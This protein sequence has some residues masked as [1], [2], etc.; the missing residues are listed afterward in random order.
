MTD[1]SRSPG[2]MVNLGGFSINLGKTGMGTARKD[3]KQVN[4][5]F[6]TFTGTSTR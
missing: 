1:V 6:I 3:D 4:G 2:C 5:A